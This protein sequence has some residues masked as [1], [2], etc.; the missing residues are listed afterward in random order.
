MVIDVILKQKAKN[1]TFNISF[2]FYAQEWILCAQ[3]TCWVIALSEFAIARQKKRC[4]RVFSIDIMV[5]TGKSVP[6]EQNKK[7]NIWST[8]FKRKD[9]SLPQMLMDSSSGEIAIEMEIQSNWCRQ[10]FAQ[11]RL[12][13]ELLA[14][15]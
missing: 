1:K 5:R 10:T 8:G 12:A 13:Y 4:K 6:H 15:Q 14:L 11:L 3:S 7:R 2:F 9:S